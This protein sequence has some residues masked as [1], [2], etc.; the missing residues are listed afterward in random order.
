MAEH[1]LVR[2]C[3]G[4]PK[5]QDLARLPVR[6]R[7]GRDERLVAGAIWRAPVGLDLEFHRV[8]G[9]ALHFAECAFEAQDGASDRVHARVHIHVLERIRPRRSVSAV[10]RAGRVRLGEI[11][12]LPQV[13][14]VVGARRRLQASF[15]EAPDVAEDAHG[16]LVKAMFCAS[17]GSTVTPCAVPTA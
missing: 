3:L 1:E 12:R 10:E 17:A 5:R 13:L 2:V 11:G 7:A 15:H 14:G 9:N 8:D 4:D 16:Q 6:F